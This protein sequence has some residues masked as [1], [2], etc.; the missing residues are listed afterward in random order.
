MKILMLLAI[1]ASVFLTACGTQSLLRCADAFLEPTVVEGKHKTQEEV[2]R[3]PT[4]T[5][6]DIIDHGGHADDAVK[7]ANDDKQSAR[8]CLRGAE[9]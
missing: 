2:M 3:D 9:K 6:R 8:S 4:S 5:T 1:S 7:R